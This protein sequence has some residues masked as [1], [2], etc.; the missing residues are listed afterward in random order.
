MCREQNSAP[1]SAETGMDPNVASVERVLCE[2]A[3]HVHHA[4]HAGTP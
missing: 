4:H 1:V 2:S 3:Q